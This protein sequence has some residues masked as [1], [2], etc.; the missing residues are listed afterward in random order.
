MGIRRYGNGPGKVGIT[1]TVNSGTV[2]DMILGIGSGS[3][4]ARAFTYGSGYVKLSNRIVGTL[5]RGTVWDTV[6]R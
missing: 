5:V 3:R 2:R 4:Y 6:Y 1:G